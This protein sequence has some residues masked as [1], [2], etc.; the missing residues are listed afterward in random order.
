MSPI[1]QAEFHAE[2]EGCEQ[3]INPGDWILKRHGKWI[4]SVCPIN[5][6]AQQPTCTRCFQQIALNGT[7]GCES[8]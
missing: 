3:P 6:A 7:C 5:R 1:V 8:A 4:H 2:C